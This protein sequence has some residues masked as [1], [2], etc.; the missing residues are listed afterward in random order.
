MTYRGITQRAAEWIG[1]AA[2]VAGG[3]VAIDGPRV[4]RMS[5]EDLDRRF[6]GGE[7]DDPDTVAN[8]RLSRHR[9][10][11]GYVYAVNPYY[12]AHDLI[13]CVPDSAGLAT[14]GY[15]IPA[16][17]IDELRPMLAEAGYVRDKQPQP[18][19]E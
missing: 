19:G 10:G 9:S 14:E 15:A 12:S 13:L 1:M 18:K 17:L 11:D 8:D 16:A 2:S 4:G 3:Y 6:P 7:W 5:A